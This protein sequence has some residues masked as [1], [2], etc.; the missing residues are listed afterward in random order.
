MIPLI[1]YL[2]FCYIQNIIALQL[3]SIGLEW[4]NVCVISVK[5][6]PKEEEMYIK[7][8]EKQKRTLACYYATAEVE[9]LLFFL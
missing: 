2:L 4:A 6:V 3:Q 5:N 1:S 8:L 9:L 7:H